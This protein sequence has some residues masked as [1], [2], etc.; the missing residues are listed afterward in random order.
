MDIAAVLNIVL[1]L[2]FICVGVALVVLIVH[3]L[4]LIKNVNKT[5][6]EVVNQ[7]KPTLDN[8]EVITD[9]LKPTIKKVDPLV[10]RVSLT[11]DAANLEIMRIDQILEDVAEITDTASSAVGTI[12]NVASAPL[13]LV[14][15]VSDKVRSAFAPKAA[16]DETARIQRERAAAK[17]AS[18]GL[19]SHGHTDDGKAQPAACASDAPVKDKAAGSATDG[20]AYFTYA[21]E[22]VGAHAADKPSAHAVDAAG[23]NGVHA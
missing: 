6:V 21:G 12:D 7:V 16:S 4:K 5:L 10:D 22:R 20:H 17:R 1:P 15:S 9:D 19:D 18:E 13:N 23:G 11:I 3:I 8:V 14:N 2:V